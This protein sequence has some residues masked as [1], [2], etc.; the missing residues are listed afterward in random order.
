MEFRRLIGGRVPGSFLLG[1]YYRPK[2]EQRIV[3]FLDM[4]C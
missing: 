2:R 3:L 4:A 1:T